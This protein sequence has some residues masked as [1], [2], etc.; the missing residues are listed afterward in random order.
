MRCSKAGDLLKI[1][2][3]LNND[4]RSVKRP[5]RIADGSTTASR[6]SSFPTLNRAIASTASTRKR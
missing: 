2:A 5:T 4:S 3:N 6:L 1:D